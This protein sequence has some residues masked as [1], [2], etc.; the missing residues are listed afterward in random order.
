MIEM[1]TKDHGDGD[2]FDS[3]SAFGWRGGEY[4]IGAG[5]AVP[6]DEVIKMVG[7]DDLDVAKQQ[8]LATDPG[9]AENHVMDFLVALDK[10]LKQPILFQR[11]DER[12]LAEDSEYLRF[13]SRLGQGGTPL[14]QDEMTYSIIKHH[15]PYVHDRMNDI[16]EGQAGR[17]ASEVHLVLGATRV[18]KV[19]SAWRPD[20][21]WEHYSRPIP[22]LVSRL[23][24]LPEVEEAFSALI[25]ASGTGGLRKSLE[26]IRERL[27]YDPECNPNGL[28]VMLLAR[29]PHE[30]VDV[31]LLLADVPKEG[32]RD[33]LAAFALHWL[34]FV[35]DSTKAADHVFS[36]YIKNPPQDLASALP[37]WVEQ[38]EK[39]AIARPFPMPIQFDGLERELNHLD[40]G[41][42]RDWAERF[43]ILNVDQERPTGLAMQ[44]LSGH[45]ELKKRA[46]LWL[47]RKQLSESY[48]YFDPTSDRD[49]DLPIDLDHRIP[50]SVF[51]FDWRT[52]NNRLSFEDK[53]NFYEFRG[54]V[55]NSLG[56]L[57]WLDASRNRSKGAGEHEADDLVS[58][59]EPWNRLIKKPR[60]DL[61]DV[62]TFQLLIDEQT[63]RLSRRLIEEGGIYRLRQGSCSG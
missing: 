6:F 46:L 35:A 55:G 2:R 59:V 62:A 41:V 50:S 34:L 15:Y 3:A 1:W 48:S 43:A 57:G 49:E 9:L 12:V 25:P 11:L 8:L 33:L 30:L 44:M 45:P 28:P 56:N 14:S 13:F 60:W 7:S 23:K 40:H 37:A 18:A 61:D 36:K 24:Q 47:Q 42:L 22:A 10:A 4:I 53:N 39:G 16:M 38:F 26:E 27:V 31:L 54:S 21:P 32:D 51:G 63:I 20:N 19:K 5:F 29:M 52:R 58:D 17:L